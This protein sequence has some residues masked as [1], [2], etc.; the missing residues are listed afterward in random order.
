MERGTPVV[1]APLAAH[2]HFCPGCPSGRVTARSASLA[3]QH[4]LPEVTPGRTDGARARK[5]THGREALAVREQSFL[6]G[7]RTEFSARA[8]R[9]EGAASVPTVDPTRVRAGS[10][11]SQGSVRRAEYGE[12]A[13]TR[14]RRGRQT[15]HERRS[16]LPGASPVREG[17]RY[18]RTTHLEQG[19]RLVRQGPRPGWH[20]RARAHWPAPG[21]AGRG[22]GGP[23]RQSGSPVPNSV[24]S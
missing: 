24:G 9:L 17:L 23:T 22:C 15:F 7:A 21:G 6:A 20:G 11:H 13:T 1:T 4:Q 8:E 2:G 10:R 14:R 16:L 3:S 5:A 12:P 19:D 18:R